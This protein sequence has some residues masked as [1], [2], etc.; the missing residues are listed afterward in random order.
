[1]AGLAVLLGA[2]FDRDRRVLGMPSVPAFTH[3]QLM[4]SRPQM[5]T[6]GSA[7]EGLLAGINRCLGGLLRMHTSTSGRLELLF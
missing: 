1:M 5:V 2:R 6:P 7:S 4:E 3:A